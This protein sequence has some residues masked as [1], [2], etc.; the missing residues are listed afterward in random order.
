MSASACSSTT[1]LVAANAKNG[2][3]AKDDGAD[4]D[5]EAELKA[6]L[7]ALL[8][9]DCLTLKSYARSVLMDANKT[10]ENNDHDNTAEEIKFIE[11][12]RLEG[13]SRSW[14]TAT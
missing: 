5:H 13:D 3:V 14:R 9:T 12:Q 1:A 6:T 2:S 7:Q 11:H 8:N 10:D 4:A